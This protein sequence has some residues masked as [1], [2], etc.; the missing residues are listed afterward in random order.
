MSQIWQSNNESIAVAEYST[1]KQRKFYDD[2][3][4]SFSRDASMFLLC[5]RWKYETDCP[6]Q[7]KMCKFVWTKQIHT[8][9]CHVVANTLMSW[10]SYICIR[11]MVVFN[12]QLEKWHDKYGYLTFSCTKLLLLFILIYILHSTRIRHTIQKYSTFWNR[13]YHVPLN[14]STGTY[15]VCHVGK[16]WL[17][18]CF[19]CSYISIYYCIYIIYMWMRKIYEYT[20]KIYLYYHWN[21]F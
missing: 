20:Y 14:D 3:Q 7:F 10:H 4:I 11:A 15:D 6:F 2:L 13:I 1:N 17:S 21:L 9:A 16:F 18:S 19:W 8:T 5:R 12:Q